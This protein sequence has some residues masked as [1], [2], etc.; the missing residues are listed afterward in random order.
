MPWDIANWISS[1]D[2]IKVGYPYCTNG[3]Q[4]QRGFYHEYQDI[5]IQVINTVKNYQVQFGFT[6]V[7]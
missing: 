7:M 5:A 3:C 4:V 2:F 6:Q 1:I